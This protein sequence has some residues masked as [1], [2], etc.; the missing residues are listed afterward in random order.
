MSSLIQ[1]RI[2]PAFLGVSSISWAPGEIMWLKASLDLFV[3]TSDPM[4]SAMIDATNT[5]SLFFT[6]PA[7]MTGINVYDAGQM[8]IDDLSWVTTSAVPVPAA[9]WLFGS[10]LLGLVGI[11]RR[12]RQ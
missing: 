12:K 8:T 11:S 5:A 2:I 6:L 7:G 4:L 1:P 9:A 10:G 3:S